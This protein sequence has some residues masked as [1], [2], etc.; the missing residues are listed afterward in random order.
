[1]FLVFAITAF[2]QRP[3]DQ[4]QYRSFAELAAKNTAGVDYSIEVKDTESKILVMAFHGGSIEPGTSE[5]GSAIAEGTFDFYTFKA[6][7]AGKLDEPSQTSS[8]LHLTST[9][10]DEP[11]LLKMTAVSDFCIGLHGF[12]GKEADFCV[13]GANAEQRKVLV[14]KLSKAFPEFKACELCCDP[15]NGVSAKN[16]INRCRH[17]G[18]QIEMS[19]KVRKKFLSEKD[20]LDSFAGEF[21]KYLK[22]LRFGA[23]L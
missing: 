7:K 10:F 9:R 13:G 11:Q 18:V 20:F 16:P 3:G 15:L 1:M 23:E 14:Q 4:D 2:A 19:P 8:T 6:L 5:L 21:K 17:Q 12:K 22:S